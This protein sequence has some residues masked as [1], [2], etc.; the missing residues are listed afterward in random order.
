MLVDQM[1]ASF[2]PVAANFLAAFHKTC[3]YLFATF[4]LGRDYWIMIL[5]D[6]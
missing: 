3:E 4:A 1:A 2:L 5:R 6:M